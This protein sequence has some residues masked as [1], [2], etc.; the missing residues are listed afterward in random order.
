MAQEGGKLW[1]IVG[2]SRGLGKEFVN[3][4]L[5]RGDRVIAT[6]RRP[7]L[8]RVAETWKNQECKIYDCDMVSSPTI[9]VNTVNSTPACPFAN[10]EC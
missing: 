10:T 6:V 7:S 2:A 8:E 5:A 9:D 4:L 3:Q 1:M